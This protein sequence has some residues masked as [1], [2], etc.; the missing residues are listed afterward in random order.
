MVITTSDLHSA[1]SDFTLHLRGRFT[2]L[3]EDVTL[4]DTRVK[5]IEETGTGEAS[6][7]L[8]AH[9]ES[10]EPHSAYDQDIPNLSVLFDNLIA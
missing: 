6:E 8:L 4:I 9:I 2:E 3:R 1:F 7:H 5:T 10:P